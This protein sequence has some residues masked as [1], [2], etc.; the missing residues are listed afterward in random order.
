[1]KT[2]KSYIIGISAAVIFLLIISTAAFAHGNDENNSSHGWGMSMMGGGMWGNNLN[3]TD[4][5]DMR[6]MHDLMWEDN[7]LSQEEFE[8]IIEEQKEHMGWSWIEEE[9]DNAE[10][11]SKSKEKEL[12]GDYGQRG[13]IMG[14]GGYGGGGCHMW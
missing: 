9:Y 12:R 5:E 7:D 6:K 1:M 11:F 4:W 14:R 3:D 13:G 8:W 10:D 2:V